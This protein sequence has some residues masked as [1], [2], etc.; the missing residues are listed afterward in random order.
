MSASGGDYQARAEKWLRETPEGGRALAAI[1]RALAALE[2][3]RQG[4]SN[5]A[6]SAAQEAAIGAG[7]AIERALGL[8]DMRRRRSI[9]AAQSDA[10]EFA[11]ADTDAGAYGDVAESA[12][13]GSQEG[14]RRI[15]RIAARQIMDMKS[16][17]GDEMSMI[18]AATLLGTAAGYDGVMTEP[19]KAAGVDPKGGAAQFLRKDTIQACGY[20]AGVESIEGV[21]RLP[22]ALWE[23]AARRHNEK[24]GKLRQIGEK[25]DDASAETVRDW[26]KRG[27][28]GLL[29]T[30][31]A[32]GRRERGQPDPKWLL[33]HIRSGGT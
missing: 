24:A 18:L 13:D 14:R 25:V 3:E 4:N 19:V 8:R 31:L 11:G 23:R 33:P 30:A 15:R 27:F 26:Q 29:D 2:S 16:V 5:E 12:L 32:Q 17:L 28:L 9:A 22:A 6:R 7:D 21:D 20:T 1:G 10:S